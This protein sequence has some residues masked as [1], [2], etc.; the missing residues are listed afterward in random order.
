MEIGDRLTTPV[1][2]EVGPGG[3]AYDTKQALVLHNY[4][5]IGTD[6]GGPQPG[7]QRALCNVTDGKTFAA[8]DKDKRRLNTAL[9]MT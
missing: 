8:R 1:G 2:F 9:F 3:S 7:L 5:A 6:G 4:C